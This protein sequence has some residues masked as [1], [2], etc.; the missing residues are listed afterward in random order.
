M[1]VSIVINGFFF[2]LWV[3]LLQVKEFMKC[4]KS[5]MLYAMLLLQNEMPASRKYALIRGSGIVVFLIL[6]LSNLF[7]LLPFSYP[8][9]ILDD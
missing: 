3:W 8:K 7:H 9:K 1:G 4:V 5:D 2:V 6:L